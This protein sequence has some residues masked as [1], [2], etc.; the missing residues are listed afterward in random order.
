MGF[1]AR[2]IVHFISYM[3]TVGRAINTLNIYL[4]CLN[5]GQFYHKLYNYFM[6]F[7]H[8]FLYIYIYIYI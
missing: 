7:D 8:L 2:R 6:Q 4:R 5:D 1:S 3:I